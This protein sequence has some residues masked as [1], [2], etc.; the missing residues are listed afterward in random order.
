VLV[1]EYD[2]PILD[3]FG[4]PDTARANRDFLRG[5]YSTVKFADAHVKFSFFTGV[6]KFTNVSLFWDLNNLTDLTL[7]APF[8]SMCGY[9]E[10][11]LDAVF[12]PELDGLDRER[13]REWY[14][15]YNWLGDERVYNP[16]GLLLLFRSRRFKAH[17]FETGTPAFLIDTLLTRQVFAP[18]LDGMLGADDLL[19]VRF[20]DQIYLFEFKVDEAQPDGRALAQLQERGYADKYRHL[21]QPIHLIGVEFSR[22]ERNVAAFAVE[23][24]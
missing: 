5:L 2:K 10:T 19:S 3:A 22:T 16:F 21:R 24:T 6:S 12:A 4:T 18:A 23:S 20:H 7:D 17:W 11:D 15:G 8:S 14:N 9:T 1:D 13:I